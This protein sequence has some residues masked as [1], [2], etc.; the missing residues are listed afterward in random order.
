MWELENRTRFAAERTFLRDR[1]G[2]E[3][4]IVVVR[5]TFSIGE[6]GDLGVA[7]VQAPVVTVPTHAGE[8]EG[9]SLISESDFVLLKPATDVLLLGHARSLDGKPSIAVEVKARV[10]GWQK[11][12]VVFGDRRWEHGLSGWSLSDPEPF[13]SLPLV[14]ERA[15]GGGAC[16]ENPVGVGFSPPTR[17]GADRRAPNLEDPSD[18]LRSPDQRPRPMGLGPIARAWPVRRRLAG[19]YDERWRRERRPLVPDDFDDR[20]WQSAP[21]DQQTSLE[22]GEAVELSGVSARGVLR[23]HLPRLHFAFR[24]QLG[25]KWVEHPSSLHTVLFE[26][27]HNRLSLVHQSALPCHHTIQTLKS[28]VVEEVTSK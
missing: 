1:D 12:L 9:T 20:F 15:F 21:E 4:L 7:D 2:A 5:S 14:Y 18:L 24:T 23:F 10:G 19:T 6:A 17:E 27:D 13:S 25:G 16:E 28:T 22:G 3:V 26:P 11:R 8:P